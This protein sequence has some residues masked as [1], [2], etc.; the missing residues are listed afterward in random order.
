MYSFIS[1]SIFNSLYAFAL[2]YHEFLLVEISTYLK[3]KVKFYSEKLCIMLTHK[4]VQFPLTLTFLI[5]ISS[6]QRSAANNDILLNRK[7]FYCFFCLLSAFLKITFLFNWLLN[8][9]IYSLFF[10]S[11]IIFNWQIILFL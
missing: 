4:M 1:H 7:C 8:F 10:L 2:M 5:L 6:F 3:L 11:H 9:Y